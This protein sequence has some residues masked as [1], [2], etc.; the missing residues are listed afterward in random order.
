MLTSILAAVDVTSKGIRVN[1]ICPSWVRTPMFEGECAK[2]PATPD[3]TKALSPLGRVAEVDE[4]GNS[5]VYLL[6]P[7]SS[8]V[9]GVGLLIDAGLTLT[10]HLG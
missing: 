4:V 3:M 6:S 5:I 8:Y 1:C 7:A 9:S 10:L 2:R